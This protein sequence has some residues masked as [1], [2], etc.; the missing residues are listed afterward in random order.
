MLNNFK[1]I[2]KIIEYSKLTNI[3]LLFIL[4]FLNSIFEVLS[5]GILLPLVGL[6]VNPDFFLDFKFFFIENPH[7]DFLKLKTLRKKTFHY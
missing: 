6:I 2:I 4:I 7:Y 3:Y 5:I 1:K